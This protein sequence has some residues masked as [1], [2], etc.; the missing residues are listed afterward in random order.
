MSPATTS[1]KHVALYTVLLDGAEVSPEVA[2]GLGEIKVVDSLMLP[3]SCD[4]TMIVNTG[5]DGDPIKAVDE[6]PFE[7]GKRLEV[8]MGAIGDTTTASLFKGD[9]ATV[10]VDF[11][12]G[13]ITVGVRAYDASAVLHR[14]RKIRVFN[15]QTSSDAVK[16]V[17][18][19][20]GFSVTTDPSGAPHEWLQQNNETDWEFI[21]RLARKIDFWV[22]CDDKEVKFVRAGT[23]SDTIEVA[24]PDELA[25]F[26]P[27]VTGVQQVEE[28][29]MRANDPKTK[30]PLTAR[31]STPAQIASIGLDRKKISDALKGG[32]LHI[33]NEVAFDGGEATKLAQ[34][35]LDRIANAY[36]EAEGVL[37]GNPRIKA[38]VKLKVSGIGS[39]L[40]GTYM[41]GNVT[42]AVRGGGSFE[43]RVSTATA[44]P[45]T[46]AALTGGGSNGRFPFGQQ[47]VIGLVSNNKDPD[48]LGRVKV[49]FPSLGDDFESGW[50]RI[51]TPSAGKERGLLMMPQVDEE[52]I[53]GFENGDTRR[54]YVL[55]SLFNGKDTPGTDLVHDNDGSFAVLSDKQ[56]IATSKDEMKLTSTKKMTVDV[57][58]AQEIKVQKDRTENVQGGLNHSVGGNFKSD[59]KGSGSLKATGSYTIESS[60]SVTIKAPS[61]TVEGQAS[62]T[63][64]APTVSING[65]GMVNISGGIIN[66]G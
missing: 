6:Q 34:A 51:A 48:N 49:K 2:S 12:H 19:E 28:V 53:V 36:V 52:V 56:I 20:A 21:W 57:K 26:H 43:S 18:G 46:L 1:E 8:K 38:G 11:G 9:I 27:R 15:N 66:L 14:S 31:A 4:L 32:K 60:A 47:L 3:D 54:G 22:L 65:S 35:T 30:R 5:P 58:D 63:L 59:A 7:V 13:G 45:T 24:Y 42:H 39:K 62:L 29:T 16:K 61:V 17:L 64:K 23:G 37:L 41:V 40:G 50:I 25:S 33:S 44:T 10:D 55:G